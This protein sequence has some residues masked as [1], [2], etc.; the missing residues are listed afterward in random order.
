MLRIGIIGPGRVG[1]ALSKAFKCAGHKIAGIASRKREDALKCMKITGCDYWSSNAQD[2]AKISDLVLITVPDSS[3]K[4]VVK[5][6]KPVLNPDTILVHTSGTL[7]ANI[8]GV[9]RSLSM[10]PIVSFAG[11]E[12]PDKSYFSIEGDIDIGKK[13]VKSI[14]GIPIVISANQ[15]PLYHSALNFGASYLLTI[16]NIGCK[17]LKKSG[18]KSGEEVIL[19]LAITALD[20]AKRLGIKKSFTGPIKRGDTE[21]IKKEI[22]ALKEMA[23]EVLEIYKLLTKETKKLIKK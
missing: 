9:K 22:N 14:G 8:L 21:I 20:N 10:H 23:P 15:K 16:L 2:I 6:I 12:L 13:L 17:L 11:G 7:P 19:S 4:D 18:L 5:E 1:T 3:I